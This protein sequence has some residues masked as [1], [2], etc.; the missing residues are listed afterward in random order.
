MMWIRIHEFRQRIWAHIPEEY[1]QEFMAE[2]CY[3]NVFRIRMCGVV[4]TFLLTLIIVLEMNYTWDLGDIYWLLVS[5]HLVFLVGLLVILF[6]VWLTLPAS[7]SHITGW[8]QFLV[9]FTAGF[10][11]VMCAV[12]TGVDRLLHGS[13]SAYILGCFGV[14]SIIHLRP[15]DSLLIFFLSFLT[16]VYAIAYFQIDPQK[17]TA[18]L[19]NGSIAAVLSWVFSVVLFNM[20]IPD[21]LNRKT[22]ER[23]KAELEEANKT[24]ENLSTIDGLTGIPNRRYLDSLLNEEWRR[25]MREQYSLSLIFIDTDFF[26][27]YNHA[28]GHLVGDDCLKRVAGTLNESLRRAGDTVARYGGEE[29]VVILPNTDIDHA[30]TLAN[31]LRA[32]VEDLQIPHGA[33]PVSRYV[34]VSLGVATAV[35]GLGS[36]PGMLIIE[37][38]KAMYRAK[39]DGGNRVKVADFGPD[40]FPTRPSSGPSHCLPAQ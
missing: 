37:A 26:K 32:R 4:V 22:I 25:A 30:V 39:E 28:C 10:A 33:S 8:H 40:S 11:L 21:F 24:L 36:T 7:T 1:K 16:F 31:W 18:N 9:V 5:V 35:P 14:A 38:D 6:L 13:I 20:R 12:I 29:F 17:V 15:R 2:Q 23:Q 3:I 27:S 34:T 19:V